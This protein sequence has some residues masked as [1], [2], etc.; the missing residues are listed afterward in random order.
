MSNNPNSPDIDSISG[1]GAGS[2]CLNFSIVEH[3]HYSSL[4]VR[5]P[6]CAMEGMG[7]DKPVLLLYTL[8]SPAE[9]RRASVDPMP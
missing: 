6:G 1:S 5:A 3:S 2:N 9:L 7:S 4:T 8:I